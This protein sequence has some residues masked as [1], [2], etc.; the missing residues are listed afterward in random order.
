MGA[1][2]VAATAG[3]RMALSAPPDAGRGIAA[4]V[5]SPALQPSLSKQG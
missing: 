4:R 5:T 2:V 1:I 3:A